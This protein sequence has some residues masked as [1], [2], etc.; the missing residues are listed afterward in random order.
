MTERIRVA[1]ADDHPL[2]RDGLR[3]LLGS[4]PEVEL[5]GEAADGESA[6]RL[7]AERRPDVLLLDVSMPRGGGVEA[8]H[9]IRRAGVPTAVVM[10]T[11]HDDDASLAAAMRGGARGYLPKSAGREEIAR[12]LAACAAGGVVF[13]SDLSPRM[14]G[15]FGRLG[16]PAR[17]AFPSLTERE[18]DVLERLAHGDDNEAIAR[19]LGMSSKTV[20]N[21]VS[22]ILGKLAARDRGAA[23]AMA[24]DAGVGGDPDRGRDASR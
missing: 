3:A 4:L 5:V 24:R 13:G 8:L 2:Y 11:M 15:L 14:P 23:I 10:L 7:V 18:R 9:A 21:H 16:D 17:D 12:A 19:R 6:A 22:V 1:F 20:R